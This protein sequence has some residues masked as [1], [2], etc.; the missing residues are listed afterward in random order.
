MAFRFETA[1]ERWS[2]YR[3]VKPNDNDN[4]LALNR[5]DMSPGETNQMDVNAMIR[6]FE[7]GWTPRNVFD[8]MSA[9]GGQQSTPPPRFDEIQAV[10][11]Q[12]KNSDSY[13][14]DEWAADDSDGDFDEPI[15]YASPQS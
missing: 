9:G 5:E 12:W 13:W 7:K 6:S 2:W 10:Y 8:Q 1:N 3:G 11:D 14:L 4:A 15:I